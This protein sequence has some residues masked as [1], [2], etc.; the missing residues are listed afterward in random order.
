MW[1]A[2]RCQIFG[3]ANITHLQDTA[4]VDPGVEAHDVRDGN[5]TDSITVS[6]RVDVNTTGT[7]TLTYTVSDA[8]GNEASLTRTVNVGIPTNYA[9]DLNATVSLEMIW[10]DPGTFTMGPERSG[11]ERRPCTRSL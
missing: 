7:Y 8:A 4:W 1:P 11:R 10:V 6:G 2:P 9:T 5:I 3:D